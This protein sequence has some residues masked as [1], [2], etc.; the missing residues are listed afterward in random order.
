MVRLKHKS[1][2]GRHVNKTCLNSTMVR[3]KRKVFVI[4]ID[5]ENKVS[6]PLWFD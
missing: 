2:R 3:L 5:N 6:I 1:L 4:R